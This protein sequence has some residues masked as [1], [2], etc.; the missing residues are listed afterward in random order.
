MQH[1]SEPITSI[2]EC[3]A[4]KISP[5]LQ[6]QQWEERIQSSQSARKANGYTNHTKC[7]C[8]CS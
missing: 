1:P 7:T 4:N 6:L 5:E 2:N 8:V 3:T